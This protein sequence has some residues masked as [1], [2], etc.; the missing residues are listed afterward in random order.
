MGVTDDEYETPDDLYNYCV[1]KAAF[2]PVMD[3]C[4]TGQNT[5]CSAWFSKEYN[6]GLK[7]HWIC[8][9]WMNPPH[10][11][12]KKWIEKA[13]KEWVE[14]DI[15]ILAII[16]ANSICTK[17]FEKVYYHVEIHPIFYRP[18]FLKD[19]EMS[20]FPSRNSYFLVI[21]RKKNG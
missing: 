4:A 13:E 12:T 8:S 6:N 16:P 20:P 3:V 17:Y 7:N 11:E 15:N 10:S 5:K 2:I 1:N 14:R 18:Q 9:S 19:G 21:W